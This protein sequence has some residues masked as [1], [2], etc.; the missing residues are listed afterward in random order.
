ML[1]REGF[2]LMLKSA[3]NEKISIS[4]AAACDSASLLIVPRHALF[5]PISRHIG[6]NPVSVSD[7]V[8]L[9]YSRCLPNEKSLLPYL[10]SQSALAV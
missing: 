9:H 5:L 6:T 4:A 2:V 10:R 3:L 7:L 8:I 1:E